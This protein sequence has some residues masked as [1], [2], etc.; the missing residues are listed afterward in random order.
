M[1]TLKEPILVTKKV[2]MRNPDSQLDEQKI[3]VQGVCKSKIL[4]SVRPTPVID[5]LEKK[6]IQTNKEFPNRLFS[7]K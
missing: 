6:T 3:V 5:R 2:L 4:F 1:I 7:L